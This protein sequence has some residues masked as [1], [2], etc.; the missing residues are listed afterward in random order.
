MDQ[1][2]RLDSSKVNKQDFE[3]QMQAIDIMHRQ[4]S[5]LSVLLLET[6]KI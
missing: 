1:L 2:Q 6:S 4:I 3:Q 5:H